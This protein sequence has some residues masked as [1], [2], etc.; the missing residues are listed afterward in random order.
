MFQ[1]M[2]SQRVGHSVAAEQRRVQYPHFRAIFSSLS[3]QYWNHTLV[4]LPEFVLRPLRVP[5]SCFLYVFSV[6]VQTFL[7]LPFLGTT[8]WTEG[9]SS[10]KRSR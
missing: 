6:E 9:A 3:L 10:T 5:V 8:F 4:L 2:G 7:D 1:F